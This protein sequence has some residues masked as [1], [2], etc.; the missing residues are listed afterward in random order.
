MAPEVGRKETYNTKAD[1][2]S[3]GILLW[4]IFE[5]KIPFSHKKGKY[6]VKWRVFRNGER[7]PI[8]NKTPRDLAD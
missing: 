2:Y 3:F 5:C 8:S 1:V 6:E 7:P 4:E